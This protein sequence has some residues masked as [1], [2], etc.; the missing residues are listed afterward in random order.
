MITFYKLNPLVIGSGKEVP[1]GFATYEKGKEPKELKDALKAEKKK[2]DAE[3]ASME[4]G[5]IIHE[6]RKE[7]EALRQEIGKI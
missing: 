2:K 1:D 4:H 5:S 3:I 7:I 6:L